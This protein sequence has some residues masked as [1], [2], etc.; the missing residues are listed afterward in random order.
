MALKV[1]GY[2][3]IKLF[4]IAKLNLW[5]KTKD[6]YKKLQSTPTSWNEMKTRIQQKFGD[7]DMDELRMRLDGIK[8]ELK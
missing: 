1:H 5:G 7:F 2:D 8:Q 6:C 4:K 3:E